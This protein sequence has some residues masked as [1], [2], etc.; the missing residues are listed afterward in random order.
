[1]GGSSVETMAARPA[2][3]RSIPARKAASGSTVEPMAMAAILPQASRP[4]PKCRSPVTAPATP[5]V[6]AAPVHT[7]AARRSGGTERPRGPAA[8]M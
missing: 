8:R 3:M 1:M 2:P 7:S 6:M 4:K 5:N